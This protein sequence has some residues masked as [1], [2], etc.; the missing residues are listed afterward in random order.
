MDFKDEY[1]EII[2]DESCFKQGE[3][4]KKEYYNNGTND[5]RFVWPDDSGQVYNKSYKNHFIPSTLKKYNKYWGNPIEPE[6]PIKDDLSGLV[7]LFQK[8]NIT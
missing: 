3:I 7:N 5:W 8:L 2:I 1:V 4:L 6:T